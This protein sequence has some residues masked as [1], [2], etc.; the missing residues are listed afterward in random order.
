[1]DF[2][3]DVKVSA[4]S[5]RSYL[6]AVFGW[7]LERG[8]CDTNP[9]TPVRRYKE[10]PRDLY[11]THDM[12][13]AVYDLALES[14]KYVRPAMELAYLLRARTVEIINLKHVDLSDVGIRVRRSKGT[15][16][17]LVKWSTRLKAAIVDATAAVPES[18]KIVSSYVLNNSRGQPLTESGF[19]SAWQRLMTLAKKRGV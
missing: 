1:M 2:R 12:Y 15:K 3:S 18:K 14:E 13:D 7:G 19:Q 9:V 5:E 17:N 8:Y 6:L 4:N 16:T 11:V 10:P